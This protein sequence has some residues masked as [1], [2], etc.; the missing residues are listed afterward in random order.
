MRTLD[1]WAGG[2]FGGDTTLRAGE[3]WRSPYCHPSHSDEHTSIVLA[4]RDT[5]HR[6]VPLEYI[7]LGLIRSV[8]TLNLK[9][10]R[11]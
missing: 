2:G 4:S 6:A 7:A 11:E 5:S 3:Q 10:K 1:N 9:G 8:S